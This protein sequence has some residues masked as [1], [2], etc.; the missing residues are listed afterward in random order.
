MPRTPFYGVCRRTARELD[1]VSSKNY[2]EPLIENFFDK[3]KEFKRIAM[4]CDKTGGGF[5]AMIYVAPA[6]TLFRARLGDGFADSRER[7]GVAELEAFALHL[8]S[9]IAPEADRKSTRLNSSHKTVSRMP[10]SA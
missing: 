6:V 4:R 2:R 7:R 9:E 3:L 1:H 8:Q 10:S 5:E